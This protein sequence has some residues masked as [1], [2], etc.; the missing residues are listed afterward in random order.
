MVAF[1]LLVVSVILA[2]DRAGETDGAQDIDRGRRVAFSQWWSEAYPAVS[3]LQGIL[4]EAQRALRRR[5]PVALASACQVMHDV[6]AV[7]VPSHLPAPEGDLGAELG[8]AAEDAHSAAHMCLAVVEQTPNNYDAEF[9]S[10]LE[11]AGRQVK[12]AMS[13]ANEYLAGSSAEPTGP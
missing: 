6:A 13:T 11:Q 2:T 1:A 4:D 7:Q 9:V 8:A 5:E 12:S 3:A 10:N